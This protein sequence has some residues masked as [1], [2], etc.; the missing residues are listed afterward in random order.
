MTGRGMLMVLLCAACGRS[1]RPAPAIGDGAAD[2][3]TGVW[4]TRLS[5]TSAYPLGPTNTEAREVCGAI[6]FVEYRG[7]SDSSTPTRFSMIG[8]YSL[9]L[10]RLG[11]DWRDGNSLPTTFASEPSRQRP[12]YSAA[13]SIR[14]EL[15]TGS[16]ERIVLLGR[17][18]ASG[19]AGDW[20]ASSA[21]GVATG[22]FSMRP[23]RPN[24][25][26]C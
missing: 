13:D 8:V 18:D 11:L 7:V 5:L 12:H 25:P 19:I 9:D 15:N 21:R 22:A 1:T 26:R 6:G 17:Q 20:S 3:L 24:A 23:H 2:R 16:E 10:R 14:I 4:D